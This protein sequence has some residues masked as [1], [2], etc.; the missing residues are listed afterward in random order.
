[1]EELGCYCCIGKS[2]RCGAELLSTI[3]NSRGRTGKFHAHSSVLLG[4]FCDRHEQGMLQTPG[5]ADKVSTSPLYIP[6]ALALPRCSVQLQCKKVR[7][8]T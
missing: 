5:P 7:L 8:E 6:F 3:Q 2:S 1:M 4:T